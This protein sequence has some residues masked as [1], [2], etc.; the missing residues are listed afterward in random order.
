VVDEP[1]KRDPRQENVGLF[2][3]APLLSS[4]TYVARPAEGVADLL[5]RPVAHWEP[6]VTDAIFA[7]VQERI[8]DH[9]HMPKQA[10]G[11]FLL[12]GLLRCECGG[13][14]VGAIGS[15]APLSLH[16]L[17]RWSQSSTPRLS[18]RRGT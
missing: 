14:M 10:S 16:G 17:G 6:I 12:T 9:Q 5:A 8:A 2:Y 4:P 13:R 11:R 1:T 7:R 3:G 15:R 18:P